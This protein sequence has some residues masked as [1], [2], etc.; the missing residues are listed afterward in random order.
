MMSPKKMK[1]IAA[2]EFKA[3]CL[4]L[5]DEVQSSKIPLIVTKHGKP[6]VTILPFAEEAKVFPFGY[7]KG[8]MAITGDIVGPIG[9]RWNAE[10]DH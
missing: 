9:E 8:R 2:G 7:M 4:K 6:M 1:Q 5:M 10:T 3:K